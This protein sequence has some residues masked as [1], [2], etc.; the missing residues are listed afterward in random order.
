VPSLKKLKP[1]GCRFADRIPWIPAAEHE[2]SPVLHEISPGH[3]VR[4]SC[5][6]NFRFED[7]V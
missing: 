2:A 5:W 4:C 6:K 1:T 3:F 7:E